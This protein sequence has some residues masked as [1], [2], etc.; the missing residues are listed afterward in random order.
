MSGP[1]GEASGLTV[2][3]VRHHSPACAGLVRRTIERLRPAYVLIEGPADFNPY[4]AD[5]ALARVRDMA[6]ELLQ[7]RTRESM[8]LAGLAKP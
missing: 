2:V 8:T 7:Q 6:V 5:L 4:L 1:A 3:G